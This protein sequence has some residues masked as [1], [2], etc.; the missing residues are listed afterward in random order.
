[1]FE[2]RFS[3]PRSDEHF[4]WANLRNK[5]RGKDKAM[6]QR[7]VYIVANDRVFDQAIALLTSL[8]D[9]DPDLPVFMVPFDDNCQGMAEVLTT[10]FDVQ[11]FPDL[12]FLDRLTQD[13]ADI[14]PRDFLK[15]PNK[16][17]KLSL[18]F[19]PLEEFIYIDTDILLF[20][21]IEE[22]LKYLNQ[23]D[24]LCCDF[25]Y[26]G[27]GLSDVFSSIVREEN[28]FSETDLL[29]VFNSGFWGSKK[30]LF[31]Y[32]RMLE[33]L[34][35]CAAHREYFDFSSGT[36]DQPI[37]NYLILTAIQRRANIVKLNPGE[38]GSWGGSSHFEER[39][40]RLY[41]QG[42]P[43]RYLHWA[44]TP[45]K[46]GGAYWDLWY[47]YRFK[48]TSEPLRNLALSSESPQK[49]WL[50]RFRGVMHNIKAS[51]QGK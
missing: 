41:D 23:A 25:H 50:S 29:D 16:M 21:S 44:G 11:I 15:L 9:F 51:L 2:P 40:Y 28:I 37:M 36:T 8:R 26:K 24:F 49:S 35:E 27:R 7:G 48:K 34:K 18:W 31:S 38:T 43:L 46:P 10:K 19:G 14:F 39:N 22:T 1:M 32:D 3:K 47:Y 5:S 4:E 45:M 33:I 17:R 13:I 30:G 6:T 20:Q 12:D 42:R